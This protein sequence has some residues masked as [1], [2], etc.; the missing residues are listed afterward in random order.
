MPLRDVAQAQVERVDTHSMRQFVD[1]ALDGE[2]ADR[3]ARRTHEGI[4]HD[5]E[6]DMALDEFEALCIIE[7]ARPQ[8]ILFGA[9]TIG[10]HH[11]IAAMDQCC[12]LARCV[13]ADRHTLFGRCATADDTID[14]LPAE[15]QPHGTTDHPGH[16]DGDNLVIPHPLAPEAATDEGREDANLLPLEAK[17][18]G[19]RRGARRDHLG[20]VVDQQGIAF[21][22]GGDG[23]EFEGVMIMAGRPIDIVDAVGRALQ[24]ALGIA[25]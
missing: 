17:Q 10:R 22:C 1:C 5:I 19:E 23:M 6:I 14:A 21:P 20:R 7:R 2:G 24:F 18:L 8:R 15:R 25:D 3:L 4:G 12:E 16:G 11:R 9:G 13:R